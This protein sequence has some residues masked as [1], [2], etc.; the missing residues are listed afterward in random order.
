MIENEGVGDGKN[1]GALEFLLDLLDIY[2]ELDGSAPLMQIQSAIGWTVATCTIATKVLRRMVGSL[3]R[4]PIQYALHCGRI[5][6][7]TQLAAQGASDI[8][9]QREGRWKSLSFMVYVRA[10]GEGAEFV[11]EALIR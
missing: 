2:P 1:N 5:G 10:G 3:G 4:D 9:I 8:Q 7:A 11:S 6:R